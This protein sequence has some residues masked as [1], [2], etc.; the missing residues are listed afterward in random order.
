MK[1]R[2]R[3]I[4]EMLGRKGLTSEAETLLRMAEGEGAT[5]PEPY[6]VDERLK[7]EYEWPVKSLPWN[8]QKFGEAL[9]GHLAASYT[10]PD[11]ALLA[12]RNLT[13]ML[14]EIRAQTKKLDGLLEKDFEY[15]RE[16]KSS[17]EQEDEE[18]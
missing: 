16:W 17:L 6:V 7:K 4:S 1:D 15:Y 13:H 11:K 2:L 10:E 18:D 8:A 5:Q 9:N 14:D 12:F 3:K